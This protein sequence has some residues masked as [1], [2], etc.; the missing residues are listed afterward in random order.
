MEEK[1]N[2][3]HFWPRSK[4]DF[5]MSYQCLTLVSFLVPSSSNNEFLKDLHKYFSYIT[6]SALLLSVLS[7]P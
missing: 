6:L 5:H 4:N 3:R 2:L 1:Q 7:G